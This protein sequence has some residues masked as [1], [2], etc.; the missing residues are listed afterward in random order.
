MINPKNIALSNGGGG[1][2]FGQVRQLMLLIPTLTKQTKDDHHKFK[3]SLDYIVSFRLAL[4][5]Q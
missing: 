5:T 3:A 2:G 1:L 4:S